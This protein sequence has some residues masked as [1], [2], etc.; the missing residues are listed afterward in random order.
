M[1]R[2]PFAAAEL[3]N[4]RLI[5]PF[6]ISVNESGSWFQVTRHKLEPGSAVYLFTEWLQHE[7]GSDLNFKAGS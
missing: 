1:A 2:R 3:T 7:I 5:H 6:D 4:G